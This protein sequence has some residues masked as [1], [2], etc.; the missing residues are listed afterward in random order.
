MFRSQ[1]IIIRDYV[2][3]SLKLLNYL[4]NTEFKILKINP[5]VVA[6]IHVA[7]VRGDRCGAVCPM[8]NTQ[9]HSDFNEVQTYSL[10][11]IC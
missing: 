1:Q 3:T 11:M 9:H 2:C 6:T 4:K 10:M 8:S 7:G 5:G